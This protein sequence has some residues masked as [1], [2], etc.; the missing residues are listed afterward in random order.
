MRKTQMALA[1][2]ALVASSAA[3]AQVTVS[4]TI[5]A[6][7]ANTSVRQGEEDNGQGN[8]GAKIGTYFSGAGGFVAGNNLV[9]SGSE[10]LGGGLKASFALGAGFDAANGGSGNGGTAAMFTQ[11]AN[12][13]LGGD[14]GSVKLGLQLSPFIAAVAGTTMLGNGHFFVNRLASI[15]SGTSQAMGGIANPG[16][17]SGG[18]FIPNAVSYTTPEVN[19]FKASVLSA[20]N[21]GSAGSVLVDPTANE[22]YTAGTVTGALGDLN[23]ALAYHRRSNTYATTAIGGNMPVGP[24]K[25]AAGFMM[26]NVH[27]SVADMGGTTVNS[28]NIGAGYDVSDALNVAIQ[29]ARNNI[30]GGSQSLTGIHGKY[31]LSKRSFAYLSYTNATNGAISSYE[32]R[33]YYSNAVYGGQ[34]AG[35]STTAI[36]I[37]H[38]F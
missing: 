33:V 19:G 10:D 4:G 7:L 12:V 21:A 29:Y 27:A 30:A 38:S 36:G 8:T 37:A 35:N 15:G 6:A 2:V 28:W 23:V 26:N 5:D 20:S 25:L 22:D 34:T 11:Q 9:F 31:S 16:L 13:G 32:G 1:A 14:F 3:L 24:L 18:F 17:G